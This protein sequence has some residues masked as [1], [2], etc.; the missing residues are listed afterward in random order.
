KGAGEFCSGGVCKARCGV[1]ADC[2]YGEV[3]GSQ[4]RCVAAVC[5]KAADCRPTE[6]CKVQR[7]PRA[8]A[9]PS[10]IAEPVKDPHGG[11]LYTMT[12]ERAAASGQKRTLGRATSYDGV[13]SRFAPAV[14]VVDGGGDVHGPS[15]VAPLGGGYQ[16]YY[17]TPAGVVVAESAD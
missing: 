2:Q 15:L 7:V 12:L 6:I 17:D 3:C 10:G 4:N 1:N 14:P 16:L 13:H 9:Q 8:T 11:V 5:G